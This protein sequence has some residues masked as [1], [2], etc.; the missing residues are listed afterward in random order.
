ME[1]R[2]ARRYCVFWNS[3][4][5]INTRCC[6]LR[7]TIAL[8]N[9]IMYLKDIV[10]VEVLMIYKSEGSPKKV[11]GKVQ[12]RGGFS[13]RNGINSISSEIQYES[14][15]ERTRIV[16]CNRFRQ[17]LDT[18]GWSI[19]HFRHAQLRG[20]YDLY[21]DVL[22]NVYCLEMKYISDSESDFYDYIE[23]T[24][25]NDSYDAVL[26]V[27]EYVLSWTRKNFISRR[28]LSKTIDTPDGVK[29]ETTDVDEYAFFNS[30]FEE[31]CVGY[32]FLGNRIVQITDGIEIDEIETASNCDFGGCRT[33]I[34][35]AISFLADRQKKDYKNCIKESI[36][37]VE[38]ICKVIVG[39]EHATLGDALKELERKRDLKGPLKAAFEKLY[40]YTND[41]GGIRHADGLFS[42]DASFEEA[43]FMLVCCSAFVNYLISEYGKTVTSEKEQ[44]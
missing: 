35:N 44:K 38:S 11:L 40:V 12:L 16:F 2:L 15:D 7:L 9:Y 6:V 36:S 14:F 23:S 13:D 39:N 4:R 42:S 26:T 30:V 32:R 17:I 33:H 10:D 43:K 34:N 21:E 41:K 37:A 25:K 24:I 27:I 31:E 19:E 28:P 3:K 5:K 22:E 8:G 20:W 1:Q 29:Y 18:I